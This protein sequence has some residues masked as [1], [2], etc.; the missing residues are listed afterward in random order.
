[1]PNIGTLSSVNITE[2]WPK[3][4][5]NFTPWLAEH[6]DLLGEALGIDLQHDQT[7]AAVGR[8]SADIVFTE[9][10]SD[11]RVVVENMFGPTDHDHL[12]KLVTY[13]AGLGAHC[14][15]LIA[16][17][18]KDEHRAALNHLNSISDDEFSFFGIT[19]EAW[20]IGESDPAPRLRV[21]VMPNNWSRTLKKVHS[22]LTPRKQLYLRF[23]GE[24]LPAFRAAHPNWTRAIK[25]S[26]DSWMSFPSK[27]S[28]VLRYIISFTR[29]G[30]LRVE[31]YVDNDDTTIVEE[32]YRQ[33]HDR[34]KEI[35]GRVGKKLKW[36]DQKPNAR[37]SRISF[38]FPNPIRVEDEDCWPEAREWTVKAM[39]KMREAFDPLL[40]ELE[41]PE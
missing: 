13:A 39:G 9:G 37:A 35:E 8:Y 31:A 10:D 32:A 28:N 40:Q 30:R 4:D 18:F 38:Y 7:E 27:L 33:L 15:V 21:E 12:G 20:R 41:L 22:G 19:I 14:A 26:K 16:E 5:K 2:I 3:E 11:K 25:P 17:E 24:F 23:W 34:A 36:G 1:M 6:A 29:D